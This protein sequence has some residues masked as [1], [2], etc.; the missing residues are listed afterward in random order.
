MTRHA[1]LAGAFVALAA[2]PAASET[3]P[4]EVVFVDGTVAA[5]LTGV[6]G[7]PENG[8]KVMT[9]AAKGNCVACHQVD[10]IPNV[11]FPGTIGPPLDG[12]ADRWSEAQLR[13][14]VANLVTI[15]A[16]RRALV[17]AGAS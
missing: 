5:S 17:A 2:L 15:G 9:T 13:G 1:L 6:A 4:G 8:A 14:I 11:Q 7:D 10:A 3:A 12:A 16:R